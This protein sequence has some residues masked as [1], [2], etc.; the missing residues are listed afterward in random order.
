MALLIGFAVVAF[1]VAGLAIFLF[2]YRGTRARAAGLSAFA[3]GLAAVAAFILIHA[4]VG[5]DHP[6]VWIVAFVSHLVMCMA[7]LL[8]LGVVLSLRDPPSAAYRQAEAALGL[9]LA[10]L[11]VLFYGGVAWWAPQDQD[12]VPRVVFFAVPL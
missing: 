8:L 10:V 6:V 9:V 5:P 7:E 4:T 12:E 2:R 1:A 11:A 3:L